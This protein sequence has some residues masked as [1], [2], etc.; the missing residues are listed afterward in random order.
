MDNT[1]IILDTNFL[2]IPGQYK[3]DIY[4]EIERLMVGKYQLY[5]YSGTLKEIKKLSKGQSKD[6][7]A[8]RLGM[9]IAKTKNIKII[10]SD[11]DYIDKAIIQNLKDKDIIATQDKELRDTI[12]KENKG[13]KFIIMRSK[14][15]LEIIND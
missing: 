9:S 5:I 15:H 13:I 8:A 4:R 2:M 10:K 12:K 6:A 1:R 14:T 11:T 3:I 7:M